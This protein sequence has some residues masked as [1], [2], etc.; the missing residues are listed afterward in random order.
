MDTDKSTAKG[1]RGVDFPFAFRIANKIAPPLLTS[2]KH[3]H[4]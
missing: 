1:K 4:P 2:A 3:L